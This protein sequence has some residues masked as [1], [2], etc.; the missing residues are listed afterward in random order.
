M[1]IIFD[2]VAIFIHSKTKH[3]F[4]KFWGRNHKI[5]KSEIAIL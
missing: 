5:S 4:L 3:M 1:F 2:F